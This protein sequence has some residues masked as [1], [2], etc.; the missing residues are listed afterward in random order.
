[1]A[2]D[3]QQLA[4]V[5]WKAIEDGEDTKKVVA[6]FVALAKRK[7]LSDRLP[8]LFTA[9]EKRAAQIERQKAAVVTTAHEVKRAL[10]KEIEQ[11]LEEYD[12][13]FSEDESVIGG[14]QIQ[15]HDTRISGTIKSF[16]NKLKR[17]VS[18]S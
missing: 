14:I 11:D 2:K 16:L 15:T 10:K 6:E 12:V 5:F 4:D 18:T 1:M 8:A 9:V 7:G 3:T 17:S 13:V